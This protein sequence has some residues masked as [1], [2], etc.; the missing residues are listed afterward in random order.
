MYNFRI[1]FCAFLIGLTFA[2]VTQAQATRTWVSGVGDDVNP[3]SRTAPCKTFAGAIA[4]T[5]ARGEISVLDPGGY[6]AVTIM[7]SITIDGTGMLASSL[8]TGVNGITINITDP[9]DMAKSVRIRGLSINGAGTGKFGILV[10]AAEKVSVE[11]TVVDGFDLGINIKA[12]TVFVRNTTI[13]NNRGPGISVEGSARVGVS[14]T[15]L[16]FNLSGFAG[17]ASS[18]TSFSNVV[19]YGNKTGDTSSPVAPPRP[20]SGAATIRNFRDSLPIHKNGELSYA[21]PLRANRN[22]DSNQS[23]R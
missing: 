7:K 21:A 23:T 15:A 16:I 8:A 2:S 5:A 19:L 10:T 6:G 13:R 18:I 22:H 17:P 12:G 1:A 14:D 9:A 11:D 4:K 3:C 20:R